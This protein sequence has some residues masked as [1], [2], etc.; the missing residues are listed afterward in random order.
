MD[1]PIITA[2]RELLTTAS[3]TDDITVLAELH[4]LAL[5]ILQLTTT[6]RH[7]LEVTIEWHEGCHCHGHDRS[8]Q[9]EA[10]TI[11]GMAKEL[12]HFGHTRME[13]L[14]RVFRRVGLS[15]NERDELSVRYKLW[16]GHASVKESILINIKVA[17]DKLKRAKDNLATSQSDLNAQRN[18]LNASGIA[19]RQN[20][21]E[22]HIEEVAGYEEALVKLRRDM[23]IHTSRTP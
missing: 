17:E 18:E 5:D 22:A 7:N 2:L 10:D 9:L 21:I 15:E 13:D 19:A 12:A 14:D 6:R 11:D 23:A 4:T 1:N 8:E 20:A 3:E 16:T